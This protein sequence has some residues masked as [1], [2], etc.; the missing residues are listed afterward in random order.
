[1]MVGKGVNLTITYIFVIIGAVQLT[2]W[3]LQGYIGT[4][5]S[6]LLS[7]VS[8]IGGVFF[9][10]RYLT[11]LDEA[12]KSLSELKGDLEKNISKS[13][14]SNDSQNVQN[15]LYDVVKKYNDKIKWLVQLLD[16]IPFPISVTDMD[17][18]WTFVNQPALK[19]MG[20][21]REELLRQK[22][23]SSNWNADICNTERCGIKM[24]RKGKPTSWFTQ[25]GLNLDFQVDTAYLLD[26]NG[27]KYGHIEVVQDVTESSRLKNR[28]QIGTEKLL[29]AMDKFALGD[30]TVH[31]EDNSS[32]TMGDLIKGFNNV[33][34]KMRELIDNVAQAALATASASTEISSSTEQMAAGA[35]EQSAQANEVAA[36]VEE[37]SRTIL[38][39]AKNASIVASSSK[40]TSEQAKLGVEK[41]DES[42]KGMARI[43]EVAEKTGKI[44][45]SL[46]GRTDQIGEIAQV[47]DE[48]A[49]QTNL[50]AL[51]AAIEAAR[52]GEQ[53]R[54]F[55]VVADEVRKLAERTTKAT[56]EIAETIK[57]VQN[58][59]REANSS[60]ID[61]GDAVNLG[62]SL[63]KDVAVTL[64]VILKNAEASYDQI[65]Q[66]ASASEEQSTTI[67]LISQNVE[68][69]NSVTHE[70][71]SGLQQVANT[72]EDLN[73]LTER[74]Q[75]LVSKFIFRK[76]EKEDLHLTTSSSSL[77]YN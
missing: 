23:Q 77:N 59:A 14:I 31:V 22:V 74:L 61:A 50:L 30:L 6:V 47:I 62:M 33:V 56:K 38:E 57:A 19:I 34:G 71:A 16:S 60:M 51:N 12:V 1:M 3:G 42:E 64:E 54:G 55:A 69:I 37:M 41:V 7:T 29:V 8:L 36:S 27:N 73:Q 46:T 4:V 20:K 58:E 10:F 67:E 26:D 18:N 32:D 35:Q 43:V 53:G 28:L 2:A 5:L 75:N 21:T 48:I 76:E 17:M 72:A 52:A 66:L 11:P 24:L 45:S 70:S 25:P 15:L 13:K 44:I 9:L 40:G 65:N 49:D 63:N 39:S 68:T